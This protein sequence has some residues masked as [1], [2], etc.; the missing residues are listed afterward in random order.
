MICAKQM[1]DK[2]CTVPPVTAYNAS[3][4]FNTTEP[5]NKV[6]PTPSG[7]TTKVLHLSDLCVPL[8]AFFLDWADV[9]WNPKPFGPEVHRRF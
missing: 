4:Y 9:F 2:F 1:P 6:A 8:H 7:K 3:L 5:V